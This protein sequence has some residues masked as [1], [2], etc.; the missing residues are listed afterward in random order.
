MSERS[1]LEL[2]LSMNGVQLVEQGIERVSKAIERLK[3]P[4]MK[5]GETLAVLAGGFEIGELAHQFLEYGRSLEV[6]QAQTGATIPDLV[7]LQRVM[8][9][10]GLQA[11]E[12]GMMIAR[13]QRALVE[14]SEHASGPAFAAFRTLFGENGIGALATMDTGEQFREI[15]DALEELGN[16]AKKAAVAEEI[17]GRSGYL[18]LRIFPELA[19]WER[20]ARDGHEEF[21]NVMSRG[22]DMFRNMEV[23]LQMFGETSKELFAGILD[24][25]GPMFDAFFQ[26]L[27][28]IDLTGIG[29]RVGAFFGVILQS[30]KDDRFPEMIGLL[31]ESGFQ[32]GKAGSERVFEEIIA[33]VE[34]RL[35]TS[36]ALSLADLVMTYGVKASEAVGFVIKEGMIYAVAGIDWLF[37]RLRFYVQTFGEQLKTVFAV[38]VNYWAS[39]I[40]NLFKKLSTNPFFLALLNTTSP[41]AGMM[42]G[43][44]GGVKLGRMDEK[45]T[46]DKP[47]PY[48][49]YSDEARKTLDAA[50]AGIASDLDNRLKQSM[51]ILRLSSAITA[52]DKTDLDALT[53]LTNLMNA[54]MAKRKEVGAGEGGKAT[55][56]GIDPAAS[57]L[58]LAALEGERKAKDRIAEIDE[59][60]ARVETDYTVT[61]AEKWEVRKKL[62]MEEKEQLQAI[63]AS[64]EARARI[65]DSIDPAKAESIRGE[66]TGVRRQAGGV[67]KQMGQMGPDPNSFTQQWLAALTKLEN[68]WGTLAETMANTFTRSMNTAIDSVSDG[69]TKMITTTQR[70]NLILYNIAK[71][72]MTDIVQAIIRMAMQWIVSHILMSAIGKALQALGVATTT[73]ANVTIAATAVPAATLNTIATSGGAA[74]AAPAAIGTALGTTM[75]MAFAEGGYTGDG[76]KYEP[77]GIVH[78]G[79]FVMPSDAVSR[80]GLPRLQAMKE[81]SAVARVSGGETHLHFHADHAEAVNPT[82][83]TGSVDAG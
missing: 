63:I 44:A 2:T 35:F 77:A 5:V 47:L 59:Q 19:K 22:G 70:W 29:Q 28:N 79:E 78:R 4:V 3:E 58:M 32:L 9:M 31:V 14:A 55:R 7:T 15:G 45:G 38:A 61:A 68:Q 82:F 80:I 75:S 42:L 39:G 36:I 24:Q 57:D 37:D 43:A 16:S 65:E 50:G 76:G 33:F 52:S 56:G 72:I 71:T 62:L 34:S 17:F 53:R 25:I 18:L 12:A 41:G 81:G 27:S 6:L 64:M 51:E 1:N 26:K 48:K 73:A 74:A 21:A 10:S 66:A 8:M 49:A 60:L 67:D 69:L 20:V 40:E 30:V 46:V 23:G 83:A 13:M 11:D 54:F